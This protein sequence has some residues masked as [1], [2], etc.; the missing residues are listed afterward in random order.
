MVTSSIRTVTTNDP[1]SLLI[2]GFDVPFYNNNELIPIADMQDINNPKTD[3]EP[4]DNGQNFGV[5]YRFS[6]AGFNN[7]NGNIRVWLGYSGLTNPEAAY[8]TSGGL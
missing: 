8:S 3:I 1:Y 6:F 4:V 5:V 7:P 2:T